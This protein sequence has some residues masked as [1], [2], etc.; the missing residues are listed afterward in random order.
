MKGIQE[1]YKKD[2][3]MRKLIENTNKTKPYVDQVT[4]R[5]FLGTDSA[6]RK[7]E[8]SDESDEM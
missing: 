5:V 2:Y 4:G 3:R 8:K 1:K 6:S 7:G